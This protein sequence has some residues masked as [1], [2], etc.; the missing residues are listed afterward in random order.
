MQYVIVMINRNGEK[1]GPVSVWGG[2]GT[3]GLIIVSEP[4]GY[5]TLKKTKKL[6]H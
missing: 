4:L 2:K 5:E 3:L 6:N 1:I